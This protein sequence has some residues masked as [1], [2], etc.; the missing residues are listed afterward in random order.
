MKEKWRMLFGT[1]VIIFTF[2]L[3]MLVMSGTAFSAGGKQCVDNGD[4]TVTDYDS[5]L[6]WQKTTAGPKVWYDAKSY[7]RELTLGGHSDWRLPTKAELIKLYKSKCKSQLDVKPAY[8]WSSTI[9]RTGFVWRVGFHN[10]GKL[11][12]PSEL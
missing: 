12:R 8:Y 11:P 9:E 2:C 6:M 10:G 7:A 4:G 1:M 3:S 5:G